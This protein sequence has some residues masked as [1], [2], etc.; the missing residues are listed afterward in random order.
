MNCL[1]QCL[2]K[3]LLRLHLYQ[4]GDVRGGRG[5]GRI[6]RSRILSLLLNFKIFKHILPWDR[7]PHLRVSVKTTPGPNGSLEVLSSTNTSYLFNQVLR[8]LFVRS[9]QFDMFWAKAWS[10]SCSG[11]QGWK[12]VGD[13]D[14]LWVDWGLPLHEGD[15][16]DVEK[17][18]I[19]LNKYWWTNMMKSVVRGWWSSY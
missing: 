12:G 19:F 5:D 7:S 13:W 18:A 10:V 4:P 3:G 9:K 14:L 16:L 8:D 6:S 2:N 11:V 17:I 15:I 1:D